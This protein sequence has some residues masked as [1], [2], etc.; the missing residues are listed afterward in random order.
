MPSSRPRP[1]AA[2]SPGDRRA[3]SSAAATPKTPRLLRARAAARPPSEYTRPVYPYPQLVAYDGSGD[4]KDA[5][6]YRAYTPDKLPD[7]HYKWAGSFA[8]GYQEWC[9]TKDGKSMSCGRRT[10]WTV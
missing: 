7:D 1:A 10:P 2:A 5:A 8:S 4:K 6:N 9:G 3:A